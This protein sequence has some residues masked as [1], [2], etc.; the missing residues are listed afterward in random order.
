MALTIVL[1]AI[2]LAVPAVDQLTKYLA[3]AATDGGA[4]TVPVIPGVLEWDIVRN[5]GASM[6]LFSDSTGGRVFFMVFSVVGI[7]LIAAIL[8]G[9]RKKLEITAPAAICL[10]AVAGGGIGNMIDR[11]FFGETL[12]TGT[13]IDFID[14]CAFPRFWKWTFN[15]ADAC[16]C[17]GIALFFLLTVI[18]EVKKMK[19]EKR[20]KEETK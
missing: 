3:M 18:E 10:A 5:S 19:E 7:A 2:L 17:V 9:F 14:F 13:V 4:K 6:G 8:F 11:T 20:K 16:I 15:F 12:F 1:I